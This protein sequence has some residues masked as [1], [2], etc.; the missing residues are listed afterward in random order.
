[1]AQNT[2]APQPVD[3]TADTG[4][5]A[6]SR[7]VAT[8]GVL[9]MAG[10][11]L[12]VLWLS[13][14]SRGFSAVGDAAEGARV[15]VRGVEETL[16]ADLVSRSDVPW[17]RDEV[18]HLIGWGSIMVV[19][20]MAFRNR[21]SLSDIAVGVFGASI[22]IEVMQK[23]FT[24]TRELEAEDISANSLGVMVGL[25]FLVALH[26]LVPPRN[27]VGASAEGDAVRANR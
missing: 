18:A 1:M 9:A 12:L 17:E 26:R 5:L 4:S 24:S 14:S 6:G 8:L 13:L 11:V 21:R 20:G 25:M 3:E 7:L 10:F 23:L 27:S 15:V 16:D 2:L 22:A 19:A